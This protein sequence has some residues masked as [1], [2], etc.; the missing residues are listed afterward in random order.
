MK[1]VCFAMALVMAFIT[2]ATAQRSFLFLQD[3]E[4][5]PFYIR[6]GEESYSSS[7]G[8]HLILSS[9][10]DSVYAMF[11]GFP[12]SRF[13]EQLFNI[14]MKGDRGFEL[15]S[16]EGRLQLFD[17]GS[18][19]ILTPVGSGVKEGQGIRKD[20]SYSMLM[21]DVVDDTAVLYS[22]V[23]DVVQTDSVASDTTVPVAT[24]QPVDVDT[25]GLSAMRK[26]GKGSKKKDK[27]TKAKADSA[28]A[29][30]PGQDTS[31]PAGDAPVMIADSTGRDSATAPVKLPVGAITRGASVIDKRDIV[32]YMTENVKGGK[33]IIYLDRSTAVT[34]T[35]RVIIPR[36]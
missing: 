2:D 30:I 36:L 13:P 35:I 19:E 23:Q 5:R 4:R 15:K 29:V 24:D 21:A 3:A 25:I 9:L 6:M 7:D 32:R 33:L 34:D 27:G 8:G 31:V 17:L 14:D 1:L 26:A 11:I 16:A 12:G 10:T 18:N 20:D 22:A 28:V